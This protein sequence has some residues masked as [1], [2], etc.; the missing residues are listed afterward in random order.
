[1]KSYVVAALLGL[2]ASI[3]AFIYFDESLVIRII[4]GVI[5]LVSAVVIYLRYAPSEDEQ[6]TSGDKPMADPVK[7]PEPTYET[8][9]SRPEPRQEAPDSTGFELDEENLEPASEPQVAPEHETP[10]D[11]APDENPDF[12][13]PKEEF[14]A[15]T[16]SVLG[17]LKEQLMAHT[18]GLYWIN[19]ERGQIIIGEFVTESSNY[20]TARRLALGTDFISNVGVS[21]EPAMIA[22]LTV[23]SELDVA[24]YYVSRE[25]IQSIIGVPMFYQGE[26]IAVISADSKA[27]DAF[28]SETV[29][30]ITRV[31]KVIGSLL[32]SYNQKFD[33][34]TDANLLHVLD[35]MESYIESHMDTYGIA[36]AIT[37]AVM[38]SLDWD[39]IAVLLNQR[40]KRIWTAVKSQTKS[41]SLPYVNEGS[42]VNMER[43]IL[44]KG[45]EAYNGGVLPAPKSREYR[46]AEGETIESRGE[47]LVLPLYS[48]REV[49]GMIVVEYREKGQYGERD[50]GILRRI[51]TLASRH[52]EVA[53]LS[54]LTSKYLLI[55]EDTQMPSRTYVLQRL[56]EEF[57]RIASLDGRGVFFQVALDNG[58]DIREKHGE[59]AIE[60]IMTKVAGAVRALAR[61]FDIAGRFGG[62]SF[63][64]F[65]V[66]SNAEEAFL[67]GEKLR[68]QITAQTADDEGLSYAYTVSIA[69]CV[70]TPGMK[71]EEVQRIARQ[72]LDKA[73]E[74]G[75]NCVKVV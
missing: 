34:K 13:D 68:K 59:V 35:G 67:R 48:Q 41:A 19:Q 62:T 71:R 65:L 44:G 27:P 26:P 14:D 54:E 45:V 12:D 50:L 72:V 56:D 73:V 60:T 20:T 74:D 42:I 39:Y 43:S 17:V 66:E 69:G 3:A 1:M 8:G 25:G 9:K 5:F 40:A 49:L 38:D 55:D 57:E 58:D 32:K 4:S 11:Y 21:G 24:P 33:L 16:H 51:G 61:P 29:G 36:S 30:T 23:A 70:V 31:S 53:V 2:F 10:S 37:R 47:L 28:G 64:M 15:L 63:C 52:L 46:F 7:K 18:V 22:Q 75:G 6:H